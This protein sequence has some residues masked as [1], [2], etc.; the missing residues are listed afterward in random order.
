MS[1]YGQGAFDAITDYFTALNDLDVSASVNKL[2]QASDSINN[3]VATANGAST[4]INAMVTSFNTLI[5]TISGMDVSN[6][7]NLG[8]NMATSI[9]D[10]FNESSKAI[11]NSVT[12]MMDGVKIGIA[13]HSSDV[14]NAARDVSIAGGNAA[15]SQYYLFS[16]AGQNFGDGI[17]IGMQSRRASVVAA[18]YALGEAAADAYA[19]AQD[20]H[21]PSKVGIKLGGYFP[22]GIAIG[23]KR[24]GYLVTNAAKDL[25]TNVVGSIGYNVTTTGYS[26][27]MNY[28]DGVRYGLDLAHIRSAGYSKP[29][30]EPIIVQA[31]GG[32]V[33]GD[34]AEYTINIP[35]TLNGRQ[36]AKATAVYNRDELNRLDRLTARRKGE[37]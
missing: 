10:G 19:R 6:L 9:N 18:A 4:G 21:S 8:A 30:Q 16:H 26:S 5:S 3:F 17:V 29:T 14:S 7:H 24:M 33:L 22:E 34:N 37:R 25:S 28:G 15:A 12:A 13:N 1:D 23:M 31:A 35:L 27:T 2:S 36:I 32:Q 11:L 20:S